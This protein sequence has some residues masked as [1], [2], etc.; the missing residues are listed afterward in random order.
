MFLF[1]VTAEV[2]GFP[3]A[4]RPQGKFRTS[5]ARRHDIDCVPVLRHPVRRFGLS[6]HVVS[7]LRG[8]NLRFLW[9]AEPDHLPKINSPATTQPPEPSGPGSSASRS[10]MTR[11]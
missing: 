4:Y 5:S 11:I 10:R 1:L 8:V 7:S 6:S 2:S 3:C 9:E